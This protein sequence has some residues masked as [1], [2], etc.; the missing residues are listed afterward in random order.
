METPKI[1]LSGRFEDVTVVDLE[2]GREVDRP[3]VAAMALGAFATAVESAG[4]ELIIEPQ[5]DSPITGNV[6]PFRKPR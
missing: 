6:L 3:D 1:T 4:D 2:T 5:D